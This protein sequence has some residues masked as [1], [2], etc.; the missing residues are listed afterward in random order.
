MSLDCAA[1]KEGGSCEGIFMPHGGVCCIDEDGRDFIPSSEALGE[2]TEASLSVGFAWPAT[3][4]TGI[5]EKSMMPKSQPVEYAF[6]IGIVNNYATEHDIVGLE[7]GAA[8][9]HNG[10]FDGAQISLLG[11]GVNGTMSGCQ[12]AILGYNEVTGTLIGGQLVAAGFNRVIGTSFGG[13]GSLIGVNTV[14]GNLVGAQETIIG[15]NDNDHGGRIY[16]NITSAQLIGHQGVVIGVN[17][18]A[19]IK[20]AQTSLVGFNDTTARCFGQVDCYIDGVQINFVGK[21]SASG[22]VNGAQ[23]L[24]FGTNYLPRCLNGVQLGF[25]NNKPPYFLFGWERPSKKIPI[26]KSF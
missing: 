2:A 20:G 21:N 26:D 14:Y 23:V 15:W 9:S 13:Q 6:I 5:V 7:I 10:D 12:F 3:F 1:V 24:F 22:Q 11:N 8:N 16:K 25:I 4:H 18:G 19:K 17:S